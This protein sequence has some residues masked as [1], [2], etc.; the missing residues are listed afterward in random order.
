M[1]VKQNAGAPPDR[2]G[3]ANA[4]WLHRSDG[5]FDG[6]NRFRQRDSFN[7]TEFLAQFLF[8]D[9]P[10]R[11]R[12]SRL[13]G[14][15]SSVGSGDDFVGALL[16]R[17]IEGETDIVL[18][19]AVLEVHN[20]LKFHLLPRDTGEDNSVSWDTI[21]GA[22]L[23]HAVRAGGC[24]VEE[25]MVALGVWVNA[26]GLILL[27]G[28]VTHVELT[29]A[30]R[31]VGDNM[32]ITVITLNS[33]VRALAPVN[34]GANRSLIELHTLVIRLSVQVDKP[35]L[36][37]SGAGIADAQTCANNTCTDR[38]AAI[39][40]GELSNTVWEIPAEGFVD[41]WGIECIRGRQDHGF[42]EVEITISVNERSDVIGYTR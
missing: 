37:Q 32:P 23:C 3:H 29:G 19:S 36:L 6:A 16:I 7:L 24:Q 38:S 21:S 11:L 40:G 31:V 18:L 10:A 25:A 2:R 20:V 22:I 17:M 33:N 26:H 41:A 13:A 1:G 30:T 9:S 8:K 35:R 28:N 15:V 39:A 34:S 14:Q 27:I 4:R 12:V 5:R 42:T